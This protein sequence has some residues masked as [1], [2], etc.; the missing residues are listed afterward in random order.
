MSDHPT[1]LALDASSVA[2]GWC[3]FDGAVRDHG[4]IRLKGA[5]IYGVAGEHASD[6]LGVALAAVGMVKI[7]RQ[8]A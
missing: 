2:I 6:A 7:E 3:V 1:L 5:D 8:A 4:T